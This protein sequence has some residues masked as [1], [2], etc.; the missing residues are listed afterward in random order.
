LGVCPERKA[1]IVELIRDGK[2]TW[3]QMVAVSSG[4]F[5]LPA[6]FVR[7]QKAD[8]LNE[9]PPD[10]VEYMV[11]L[12]QSNR[13]RNKQLFNQLND[14][15]QLMASN[16]IDAV[17]LK[18]S[19][20][21]LT[22]LYDDIAERMIGDI[23]FLVPEADYFKAAELLLDAGYKPIVEVNRE[24]AKTLKHFPRLT[25]YNYPAAVEVHRQVIVP[26]YHRYFDAALVIETK[27]KLELQ[28]TFYIPSVSHL[29]IHNALN[30]QINDKSYKNT[31]INLRQLYDL[32]LLS[33]QANPQT[34]LSDFAKLPK[35]TNAYLAIAS[36][37]FNVPALIQ[38]NRTT[39]TKRFLKRFNFFINH[40]GHIYTVYKTSLYLF[41]RFS[42]YVI[43]PFQSFYKKDVRLG[44]WYRLSDPKW[45]RAHFFSY[46]DY[47][48]PKRRK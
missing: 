34:V 23:D 46:W 30:A 39:D 1:E 47:F 40:P 16:G 3:E 21:L 17:F 7:F 38:Y 2:V 45:Y 15:N 27:Q 26:P 24:V 33:K 35:H 48:F 12:T 28:Q 41:E 10:L 22:S 20:H 18:G 43:L 36:L 25:N 42:R 31:S 37:L 5:V 13:E 32:L 11:Y 19:A 4:Q 6:L 8:I 14:I 44:L 9:L 29:I